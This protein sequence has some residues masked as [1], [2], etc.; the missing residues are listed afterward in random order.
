MYLL[1]GIKR[2]VIV[3]EKDLL[4]NQGQR[5][6]FKNESKNKTKTQLG[7]GE[8]TQRVV[9]ERSS[10]FAQLYLHQHHHC[11]EFE[12]LDRPDEVGW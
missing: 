4:E 7:I 12:G 5:K 3:W 8:E 10:T 9:V 11:P 2:L 1:S 6:V